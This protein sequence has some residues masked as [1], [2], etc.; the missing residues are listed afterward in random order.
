VSA[1]Y[2]SGISAGVN[3][4]PTFFLNGKQIINPK[5]YDEFKD[6]IDKAIS[7]DNPRT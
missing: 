6:L 3:S 7:P 4:T 2:D 5:S 1:D